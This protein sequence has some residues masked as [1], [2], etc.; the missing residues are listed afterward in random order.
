[1]VEMLIVTSIM[2]MILAVAIPHFLTAKNNTAETIVIREMQAIYSA[3]IQYLSQ[4]GE[5]S[6]TLAALGP[7]QNAAAG[8]SAAKLI[9]ASLASGSKDGYVF[10]M[11]RVNEG[12]QLNAAPKS[13][14]STGR[15][16]F[17]LDQDGVVHY[18]WGEAPA[19]A[20]SPE[21]K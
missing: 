12:F 16:T 8:P 14:G 20:A 19:T 4:F 9:P 21:I 18:N 5:F 3:Q 15:R 1:M 7:P 10:T 17:Y 2:A 13:F 11:V 6:P